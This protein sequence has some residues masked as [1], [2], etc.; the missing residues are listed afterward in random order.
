MKVKEKY[1]KLL[2][3]G[4]KTI[5]LRLFDEKRRN[6]RIGDK[7]IFSNFDDD[8]DTF[9]AQ[10]IKLYRADD[11]AALG[12]QIPVRK[13]GFD[14]SEELVRVMQKFYSPEDQKKYGVLGIEIKREDIE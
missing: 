11:F 13:A 10:V 14:S 8:A 5:E 1:Y 4:I 12:C 2:K 3:S 7:I 9:T 6:I